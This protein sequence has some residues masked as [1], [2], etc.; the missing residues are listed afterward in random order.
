[1]V[2]LRRLRPSSLRLEVLGLILLVGLPVAI[3][4]IYS[5]LERRQAD[6]ESARAEAI[7]LAQAYENYVDSQV[8]A[9]VLMLRPLAA[10]FAGVPTFDDIPAEACQGFFAPL[11]GEHGLELVGVLYPDGRFLCTDS[12]IP[13]VE[14]L[15][16]RP[17]ITSLASASD[18]VVAGVEFSPFSGDFVIPVLHPIRN[19]SGV[20]T[21]SL[22]AFVTL[23]SIIPVELFEGLPKGSFATLVDSQRRIV[24]RYPDP[25]GSIVGRPVRE[26]GAYPQMVA[27][28]TG[29]ITGESAEGVAAVV[30]FVP[31][32]S[33]G[34]GALVSVGISRDDVVSAA[35][36]DLW[37]NSAGFLVVTV[38]AIS[39]AWIGTDRAVLEPLRR[40]QGV[41][42][43]IGDG[44]L[45]ARV[46]PDYAHGDLG[47]F[48]RSLDAM[49][50]AI[51]AR[52]R[53]IHELN[54]SLEER[55]EERTAALQA[56]NQ[57]LEAFSYSVS[58]D[59]RAPLRAIDGFLQ[60]A[61]GKLGDDVSPEALQ[62]LRRV[63]AGSHRMGMLID[64]LLQYS[65][66]GRQEV[67]PR[68]F[69]MD[70]AVK[71]C[72]DDVV[73]P[74]DRARIEFEIEP[75]GSVTADRVLIR[76][77]LDNLVGNAVKFSRASD[78]PKITIGTCADPEGRK[79]FFIRDNGV[80]FDEAYADKM[81]GMLQRLH[82]QEEFE[83]TG[84][85]LAIVQRVIRKH[86][87]AIW[88]E[89]A[90]GEGATFYFTVG[91]V[92]TDDE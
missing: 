58:H 55:V 9:T 3:L 72:L 20:F 60:M 2:F 78:P 12:A 74:A 82:L 47:D 83:G 46:A 86:D 48:G 67:S 61:L 15:S 91:E 30:G 37:R 73:A 8:R 36:N 81:F 53:Q 17:F 38:L 40:V 24:A 6:E 29:S 71:E 42:T 10:L 88:A 27:M 56:A 41:A 43:R 5:S 68:G 23:E 52:T 28:G 76:R 18:S 16:G 21:G 26:G 50:L 11:T 22:V 80:G 34:D 25:T 92:A 75:L 4:V 1:M 49:A 59:L 45:T 19:A 33:L 57:E 70:D 13:T 90:V 77:V 89:S 87:G 54:A 79:A 39:V 65:R 51:D 31:A 69:S 62:H 44:D 84:V 63:E 85:G 35:I 32:P 14:S 66:V 7:R 64:D